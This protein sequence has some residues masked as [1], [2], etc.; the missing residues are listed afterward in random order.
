MNCVGNSVRAIMTNPM[1]RGAHR[2]KC[3]RSM[4]ER[5][6]FAMICGG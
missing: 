1:R 5:T 4:H 3:P 2:S 6:A